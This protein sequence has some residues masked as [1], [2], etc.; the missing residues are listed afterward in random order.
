[1]AD[2]LRRAYGR[3]HQ[4]GLGA[5]GRSANRRRSMR[6]V[7]GLPP[8]SSCLLVDDVLTTGATLGECRRV[9]EAGGH[10]VLGALVLAAT[11]SAGAVP[12]AGP[13]GR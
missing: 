11:P 7:A 2:V 13:G 8:R 9:L 6:L 3:A 5:A 4:A 12:G 1:M 10:R